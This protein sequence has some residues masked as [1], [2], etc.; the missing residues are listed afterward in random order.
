V[1]HPYVVAAEGH[2]HAADWR[3]EHGPGRQADSQHA[4]GQLMPIFICKARVQR[5]GQRIPIDE[6][7][8]VGREPRIACQFHHTEKL[9]ELSEGGVVAGGNEDLAG[10]GLEF[11]IR[12]E[13]GMRVAGRLRPL[14]AEEEVGGMRVQQCHTAVMR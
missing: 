3:M 4:T 5:L 9:T 12:C 14:S 11:G 8:G 7:R 13:I 2:A 6:A 10:P 1:I